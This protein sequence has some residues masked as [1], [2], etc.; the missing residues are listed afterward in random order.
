MLAKEYFSDKGMLAYVQGVQRIEI[1]TGVE[2]VKHQVICK[3]KYYS[4]FFFQIGMFFQSF[5]IQEKKS[6]NFS[7]ENNYLY[8][9]M[10]LL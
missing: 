1:R 8:I 4:T 9:F 7:R 6:L 10:I 2:C 3:T 5:Q